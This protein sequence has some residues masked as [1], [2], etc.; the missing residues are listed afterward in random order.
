MDLELKKIK[1][2]KNKQTKKQIQ[3]QKTKKSNKT[4]D[5]TSRN[6]IQQQISRKINTHIQPLYR[7]FI[8]IY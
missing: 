7:H 3:E 6:I 2:N 4:F 8:T 1:I 5:Q